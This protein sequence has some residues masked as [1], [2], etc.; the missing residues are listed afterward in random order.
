MDDITPTYFAELNGALPAGKAE[1]VPIASLSSAWTPRQ[2][3]LDERHVQLL[4]QS[5]APLPPILVQRSTMRVIDGVHRL[6][7]ARRNGAE[8]ILAHLLEDD[9]RA[10]YLR[11]V[12]SNVAHGLPLTLAERRAA[13]KRLLE[14]FPQCSD[15]SI[16]RVS[17]LSGKTVAALRKRSG[18]GMP[19]ERIGRDGRVRPARPGADRLLVEELITQ[20][21]H[22]SLRDLARRAGVSPNTVRNARL[23]MIHRGPGTDRPAG[24]PGAEGAPAGQDFAPDDV[25]LTNLS[26]DPSLRYTETGRTLLRLLHQHL[27]TSLDGQVVESLPPHCLPLVSKVARSVAMQWKQF[28]EI[29]EG[30]AN[31][32]A[33]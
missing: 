18:T 10:A 29:A 27:G 22:A 3:A 2:T 17:G 5:E 20:H 12:A 14:W 21:P 31:A 15:R 33:L 30:R 4:A 8:E 26:R 28:A 7:A 11:S 32:S 24:A 19:A 9:D 6:H 16:G 13:A 1:L 23:R 25:V